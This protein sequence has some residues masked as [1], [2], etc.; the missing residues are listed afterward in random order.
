MS[1][2]P[3][4]SKDWHQDLIGYAE[5]R[6]N[7]GHKENNKEFHEWMKALTLL[8]AS[9]DPIFIQSF[10]DSRDCKVILACDLFLY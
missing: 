6:F 8:K 4:G 10:G 2:L 3:R 7:K 9:Q 5:A 1:E